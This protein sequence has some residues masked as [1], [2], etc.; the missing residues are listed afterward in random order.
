MRERESESE[1]GRSC[2]LTSF[3][4]DC[5]LETDK[6]TF[7]FRSLLPPSSLESKELAAAPDLIPLM[8]RL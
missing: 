3:G 5:I 6:V 7:T 8:S 4:K 1:S 2:R